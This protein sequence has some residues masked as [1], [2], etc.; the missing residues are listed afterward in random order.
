MCVRQTNPDFSSG[1]GVEVIVAVI[2][3]KALKD[4]T[5]LTLS[6]VLVATQEMSEGYPGRHRGDDAVATETFWLLTQ[7][8]SQSLPQACLAS[9]DAPRLNINL[10]CR[11]Q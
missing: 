7:T 1:C 2:I 9:H 3:G 5:E 11:L 4:L 10:L 6:K 8:T